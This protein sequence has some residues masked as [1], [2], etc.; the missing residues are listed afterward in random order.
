M[1]E[2]LSEKA[3]VLKAA[4]QREYMKKYRQQDSD[5]DRN[6]QREWRRKNPEK[7]KQYNIRYWE[8]KAN[9]APTLKE[10]VLALQEQGF[11]YRKIGNELGISKSTVERI[12][13]E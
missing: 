13:N 9:Q 3:K 8:K 6:Y 7:V 1:S 5:Y 11:S 12:L 10:Q 2:E 4:Y